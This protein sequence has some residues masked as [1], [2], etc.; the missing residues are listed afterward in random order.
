MVKKEKIRIKY[1][2]RTPRV[3]QTPIP[4]IAKSDK[5]GEVTCDPVGEFDLQDGLNLIALSGEMF[6]EVKE[7]VEVTKPKKMAGPP[8]PLL[9]QAMPDCACGCGEQLVWKDSY[10]Y[11]GIPKYFKGHFKPSKPKKVEDE[12]PSPV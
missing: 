8:D 9:G 5:S 7:N 2:G 3:F 4:F 1:L 12:M 10:K 11:K 6:Q